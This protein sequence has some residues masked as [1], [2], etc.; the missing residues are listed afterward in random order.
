MFGVITIGAQETVAII[1]IAVLVKNVK[2][3]SVKQLPSA[4]TAFA[5][6]KKM[7]IV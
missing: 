5:K 4:A 7:K 6:K 2:T 3:M 1:A